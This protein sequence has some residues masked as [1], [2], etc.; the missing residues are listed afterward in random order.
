MRWLLVLLWVGTGLAAF[1]QERADKSILLTGASFATSANAWFEM[2]CEM[3]GFVPVNR[4]KGGESIADAANRMVEGTLY[5][6]E[7]LDHIEAFVIMQVHDRNVFDGFGLRPGLEAYETPFARDDYT[8][9]F[10]YVIRR[11]I[12]DCYHLKDNP[13]SKYYNVPGGKP[14][15]IILSTHWHDAREAY[16]GS[17]RKLAAKWGFP[18]IEFDRHIGFSKNTPHPIT[19]E[20]YSLLYS[21]DTQQI[22]GITY[23]WHPAR[24]RDQYIQQRM[25]A[26]FASTIRTIFPTE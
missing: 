24:G 20:Q 16:N 5:T 19:G 7:E 9:A 25:A 13:E 3:T 26:I 2:G 12:S 1:G 8:G 18:V 6:I 15:V 17:V 4:A 21:V 14:A 10:D 11:Y 23:G 22:D